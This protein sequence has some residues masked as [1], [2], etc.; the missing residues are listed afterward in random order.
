MP[1]HD[2]DA[3]IRNRRTINAF[4]TERPDDEAVLAA[5]ESGCWAPNHKMTEPWRFYLLGEK[6]ISQIVELNAEMAR[7]SKGEAAAQKK[8]DKWSTI[9]G[10][11]VVTSLRSDDSLRDRENYAAVCC[12]VQNIALSLWSHGIGMKWTTGDVTRA[13]EIYEILQI[14]PSIEDIVGVLWYGFPNESP[15]SHRRPLQDVLKQLP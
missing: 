7:V 14:D 3:L 4:K 12:A 1:E 10:W 6:T 8:R 13:P 9:P 11:I 5:L 15:T 2:I